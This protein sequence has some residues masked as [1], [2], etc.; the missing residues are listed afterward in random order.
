MELTS[1]IEALKALKPLAYTL[2][3]VVYSD[4]QYVISGIT[5]WIHGWIAKGWKDVKNADLWQELLS[6]TRKFS[7]LQF[8]KVPG[9]ADCDGNNEVDLLCNAAMD[10]YIAAHQGD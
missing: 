6:Q 10:Q 2:P 5:S 9:H 3:V 4:S 1:V 7:N 8:V